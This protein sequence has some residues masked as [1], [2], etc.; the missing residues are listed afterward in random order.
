MAA[1]LLPPPAADAQSTNFSVQWGTFGDIPVPG[2][3]LATSSH[4]DL[5]VYEP[6]TG[7]WRIRSLTGDVR[8]VQF[9]LPG[10]I[11]TPGDF[12]GDGLADVAVWRP[13]SGTWF[14]KNSATGQVQSQQWGLYG[15]VPVPADYTGDRRTDYVVWRPSDGSW[16]VRNS[17]TGEVQVTQWG[18]YG[19]IP[20]SGQLSGWVSTPT[21]WRQHTGIGRASSAT[22]YTA[23]DAS[24]NGMA[25]S[26]G[27]VGDI[28]FKAEL[29]TVSCG[30]PEIAVF[31]PATGEWWTAAG[32]AA[33]FGA[34]GD[35]PVPADYVGAPSADF[36]IWRPSTGTWYVAANSRICLN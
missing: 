11:P 22:W 32:L 26:L 30:Y 19:D 28:P 31:R 21:V 5:A 20:V 16:Y 8:V 34:I 13:A 1:L 35:V 17:V 4:T 15:D 3:Y 12:D 27:Q 36:A 18:L 9:G 29:Y 2:R 23:T 25:W 33:R 24:G 10:D 7:N 6:T 14:V